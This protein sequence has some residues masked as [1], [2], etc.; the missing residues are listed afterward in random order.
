MERSSSFEFEFI[1][2]VLFVAAVVGS[3][4]I[5]SYKCVDV[6]PNKTRLNNNYVCKSPLGYSCKR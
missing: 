3:G 1:V 2:I 6:S 4:W 5:H